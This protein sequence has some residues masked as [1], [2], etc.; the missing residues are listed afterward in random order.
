MIDVSDDTGHETS[1]SVRGFSLLFSICGSPCSGIEL[2]ATATGDTGFFG[3]GMEF[4]KTLRAL[5]EVTPSEY[6][7]TR[8][9]RLELLRDCFAFALRENCSS[10]KVP[11]LDLFSSLYDMT[12]GRSC[13][14]MVT[15]SASLPK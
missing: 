4:S 3:R 9:A 8:C 14:D 1:T 15:S 2:R 7:F 6:D 11:S 12:L 13:V 10:S 5:M